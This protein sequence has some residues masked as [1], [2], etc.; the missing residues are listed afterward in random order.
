MLPSH[1]TGI[2]LSREAS[3]CLLTTLSA[4]LTRV[5]MFASWRELAVRPARH[6]GLETKLA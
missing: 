1:R 2:G 4:D 3:P 5:G 6:G